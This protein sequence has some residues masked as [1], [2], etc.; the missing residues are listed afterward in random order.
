MKTKIDCR[1]YFKELIT[2]RNQLLRGTDY[3]K[4]PIL[5]A[6][7]VEVNINLNGAKLNNQKGFFDLFFSGVPLP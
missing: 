1:N 3:F 2:A 6:P 4:E 5:S 7:E